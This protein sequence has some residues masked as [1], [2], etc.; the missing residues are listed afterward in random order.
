MGV[1]MDKYQE[2]IDK[3]NEL[4]KLYSEI[5]KEFHNKVRSIAFLELELLELKEEDDF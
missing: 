1:K 2:R 4:D 3:Q 5:P